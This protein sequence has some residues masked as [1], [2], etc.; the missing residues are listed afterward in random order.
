M[1]TTILALSIIALGL[2]G[3]AQTPQ[4]AARAQADAAATQEKL[5]RDLAGLTP[6]GKTDCLN[7]F[8]T[9]S[10]KSYGSTLVYSVSRGLKYVTDTGGG[11]E[12]TNRG[13]IL[14]TKSPTGRLCRGDIATTVQPTSRVPSGS[15]SIGEFTIYKKAK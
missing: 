1:R 14:I 8:G 7:N 11:C 3:C 10:M 6:T 2:A 9:S 15:C 5:G 4:E 13:D 12:A